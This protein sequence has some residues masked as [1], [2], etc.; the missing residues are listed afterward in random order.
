MY[1]VLGAISHISITCLVSVRRKFLLSWIL[2]NGEIENQ[3]FLTSFYF[4]HFLSD[5]RVSVQ[6]I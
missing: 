4:P 6:F 2:N 3:K 1:V 5:D